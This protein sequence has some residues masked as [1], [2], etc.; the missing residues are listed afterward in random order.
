M[1][2]SV[3]KLKLVLDDPN[4]LLHS[5]MTIAKSF[6]EAGDDREVEEYLSLM[7]SEIHYAG[8]WGVARGHHAALAVYQNEQRA[9]RL[10]WTTR[11][12][13]ITAN[14]FEREGH[15][16]FIS[17]GMASIPGIGNWFTR[18]AQKRVHESLVVRDGK[19]VFRDLSFQWGLGVH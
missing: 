19:V 14:T 7:D 17:G 13:A 18:F 12:T 8:F 15:V 4:G 9:L 2:Y 10:T 6:F 1:T 11:A 3:R 5:N 16:Q